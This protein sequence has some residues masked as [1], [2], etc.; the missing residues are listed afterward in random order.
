MLAGE[1]EQYVVIRVERIVLVVSRDL[2]GYGCGL[3]ICGYCIPDKG[4]I[5]SIIPVKLIS[6]TAISR[7]LFQLLFLFIIANITK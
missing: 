3:L 7:F 2:E 1:L 5:A 6:R 4:S